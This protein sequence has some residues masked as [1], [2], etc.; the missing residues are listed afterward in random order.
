MAGI[1]DLY[2]RIGMLTPTMGTGL[3]SLENQ[4]YSQNPH[5]Q[6]TITPN[7]M[8][9]SN[10]Q[11]RDIINFGQGRG[12]EG[13]MLKN[14]F[15]E[16]IFEMEKSLKDR[17]IPKI[18]LPDRLQTLKNQYEIT[19]DED[20]KE[21]GRMFITGQAGYHLDLP[22]TITKELME[23]GGLKE[24]TKN[25]F[26]DKINNSPLPLNIKQVG[27]DHYRLIDYSKNVGDSRFNLSADLKDGKVKGNLGYNITDMPIANKTTFRLGT[28]INQGG[29][30]TGNLG[31]R[32]QPSKDA[33]IDAGARF[34]SQGDPYYEVKFGKQFSQGGIADIDIFS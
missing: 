21:I 22:D 17:F 12:S 3:Q 11:I 7:N 6:E 13:D 30:A 4:I 28:N 8:G 5:L 27:K 34:D 9:L 10:K 26:I 29:K 15:A 20:F 24:T 14:I 19:K 32:Y 31:F 25:I 23:G 33:Y 16:D 2:K 1:K 18:E